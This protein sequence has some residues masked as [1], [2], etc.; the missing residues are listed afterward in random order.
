M[1]FLGLLLYHMMN[2]NKDPGKGGC[3]L[4]NSSHECHHH[5]IRSCGVLAALRVKAKVK[6]QKG[7][8]IC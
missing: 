4:R 3:S 1:E 6:C 2:A 8:K 5:Y 7:T